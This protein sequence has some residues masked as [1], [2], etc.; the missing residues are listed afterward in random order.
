LLVTFPT[1][2]MSAFFL[3]GLPAAALLGLLTQRLT[4]FLEPTDVI[5]GSTRV[6]ATALLSL[7][8][9]AAPI[10]GSRYVPGIRLFPLQDP[11]GHPT[12]V[13]S[14]SGLDGNP[15]IYLMRRSAADLTR[16]T[17][18]PASDLWPA[19]SPD[20]S[21]VVFVSTRDGDADVY[22]L[23]VDDPGS[24]RQLTDEPG[25]DFAPT[26]SPDGT[27]IAFTSVRGGNADI[28][29]MDAH[30]GDLSNLTAR[31]LADDSEPTWSPDGTAIAFARSRGGVGTIG[32]VPAHGGHPSLLTP[33]SVRWA[34]RP[35][36]SQDGS[37][38]CFDGVAQGAMRSD[39]FT[40]R[41]DGTGL[42][43]VTS[44]PSAES[45][46]HWFDHDR[47]LWLVSDLPDLGYDFAYYVPSSGGGITLFLRG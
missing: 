20:G 2:A 6:Q 17:V 47:F 41:P 10:L 4:R 27:R 9:F 40:I 25:N 46:C 1:I 31:S 16:L 39:I 28:W 23:R 33:G 42:M 3:V 15:E 35:Q 45:Y 43:R 32:I 14:A 13:F 18:D 38:I 29:T 5:A 26:W 8:A 44:D 21:E 12:I 36:W 30:G 24:I 19:L 34:T 22:V 11:P 7:L 37:G